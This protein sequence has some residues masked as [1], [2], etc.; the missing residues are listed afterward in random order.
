MLI[1]N[2]THVIHIDPRSCGT[3]FFFRLLSEQHT[4]YVEF[5]ASQ[6]LRFRVNWCKLRRRFIPLVSF[7]SGTNI[8]SMKP[9]VIFELPGEYGVD[10]LFLLLPQFHAASWHASR[11]VTI[12]SRPIVLKSRFILNEGR[13]FQFLSAPYGTGS[14]MRHSFKSH[15]R[16]SS[17]T[18]IGDFL[19]GVRIA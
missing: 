3:L 11:Q 17:N 16:L 13:H 12:V 15:S 8:G 18:P 5:C 7:L 2:G 10:L 19:V 4:L 1:N 6:Y 9:I 14:V